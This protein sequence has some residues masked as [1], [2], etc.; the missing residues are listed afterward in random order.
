[1]RLPEKGGACCEGHAHASR[2]G[3][4]SRHAA[5]VLVARRHANTRS[6]TPS[7]ASRARPRRRGVWPSRAGGVL[8]GMDGAGG[9]RVREKEG[10]SL[11]GGARAPGVAW[12]GCFDF[13][14]FCCVLGER[15]V[16]R[17]RYIPPSFPPLPAVS[18]SFSPSSS[19]RPPSPS[20]LPPPPPPSPATDWRFADCSRNGGH[21]R[22]RAPLYLRVRVWFDFAVRVASSHPSA[23]PQH[24]G[25][26][27]W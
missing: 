1:M 8:A 27:L 17:A 6:A 18:F 7:R 11:I 2:R 10:T 21:T 4:E 22:D 14:C 26:F 16:A 13:V 3:S 9:A 19:A 24:T 15:I 5:R 12:T 25:P 23:L 20:P